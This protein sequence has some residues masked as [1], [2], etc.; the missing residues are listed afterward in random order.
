V[1]DSSADWFQGVVDA[2]QL[3]GAS[4]GLW[5]VDAS[6]RVQTTY[7]YK[8]NAGASTIVSRSK[9]KTSLKP[10]S[11]L[12]TNI[13]VPSI[14]SGNATLLF[15]PDRLLVKNGKIFSDVPY[16][17]LSL[18]ANPLRFTESGRRPSDSRQ[19]DTTW[20]Y[21]NVRGGPDRRFKDNRQY[22]VMLYGELAVTNASGLHW[23]LQCS[24]PDATG[25]F[26]SVLRAAPSEILA[27]AA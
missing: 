9:A 4:N 10:P 19:V 18:A 23:Q 13:A 27:G 24:R 7:Q 12:A 8:V 15:L 26:D 2:M 3:L 21:V 17:D 25:N 22:P 1:N 16:A 14:S 6:G 20:Q 5:R 11:I